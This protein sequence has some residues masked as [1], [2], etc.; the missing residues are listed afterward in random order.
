MTRFIL[1]RHGQTEW[2]RVE[3]FRGRADLSLDETGLRQA[4]A[5]ALKLKDCDIAAIYSSPLKRARETASVIARQLGIPV[6]LEEGLID[7]DFGSW[8]GLSPEEAAQ[9]DKAL[10]SKWLE[11]PH[12]VR[13]PQGESLEDVRQR[14]VA[15]VE[16]IAAEHS[17]RTVILVSHKVVCQTLLVAM[18]GL[19]NSHFWQ[20]KQDVCAINTFELSDSFSTVI[21]L[22]DTCHLESLHRKT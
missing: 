13:F 5:A 20:V 10:Y 16:H 4:L 8:Q 3:R 21:Q 14:V 22:N 6:T 15:A 11:Y 17:N 7:I 1:V 9:Q 12:Q 19:D 2:N 18:L